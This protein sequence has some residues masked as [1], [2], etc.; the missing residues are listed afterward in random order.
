MPPCHHESHAFSKYHYIRIAGPHCT[1]L[2]PYAAPGIIIFALNA[3][4]ETHT[5]T[6]EKQFWLKQYIAN[7]RW[8]SHEL[9]KTRQCVR[10][11]KEMDS[12]SIGLYPQGFE[13]PQ[14]RLPRRKSQTKTSNPKRN[15]CVKAV[16]GTWCSGNTSALH[17]EG[18]GF[19]PHCVNFAARA[20]GGQ[21]KNIR[22][23]TVGLE[24]KTTRL[25]ALRSAN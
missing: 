20:R 7:G 1:A 22:T 24:P 25:R 18:P 4:A 13:S 8:P 3:S 15:S 14:C 10:V 16:L 23:P 6:K 19:N 9:G 11:V 12:K 21:P 17:A 2:L 5:F